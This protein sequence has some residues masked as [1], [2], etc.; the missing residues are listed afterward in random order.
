MIIIINNNIK[1]HS[2]L[3]KKKK[4]KKKSHEIFP[5]TVLTLWQKNIIVKS[6]FHHEDLFFMIIISV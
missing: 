3:K 6:I 5:W 1:C 2:Y 4:K